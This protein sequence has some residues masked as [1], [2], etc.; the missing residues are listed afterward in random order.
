[1]NNQN[2]QYNQ[3]NQDSHGN[4]KI[5]L[6]MHN[7]VN[8][9]SDDKIKLKDLIESIDAIGFGV[10][11]MI[12]SIG[13]IIPTPPPFPS[14]ISIPLVLFSFQMM[15]GYDSPILPKRFSNISVNRSVLAKMIKKSSPYLNKIHIISKPRFEFMFKDRSLKIIGFFIFIFSVLILVPAPFTNFIPGLGIFIISFGILERD[16]LVILI[17]ILVGLIGAS[18]ALTAIFKGTHLILKMI[19]KLGWYS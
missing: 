9:F 17:G 6:I 2:N 13:I 12:F 8:K 3:D 5:S 19:S 18:I 14:L 16:G 11:M 10:I 7:V 4:S 15:I 1:M